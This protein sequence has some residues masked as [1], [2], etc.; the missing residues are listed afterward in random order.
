MFVDLVNEANEKARILPE[1]EV[2]AL[3]PLAVN[4]DQAATE[5]LYWS[6]ARMIL[7]MA[8]KHGG[9]D[10][11]MR[12]DLVGAGIIGFMRCIRSG[13]FDSARGT[14]STYVGWRI[15]GAMLDYINRK[16]PIIRTPSQR[17]PTAHRIVDTFEDGFD[18]PAPPEPESVHDEMEI[19]FRAIES[20]DAREATVVKARYLE[21]KTL[22]E[23][24]DSLH[25]TK[26]RIRQIQLKAVRNLRSALR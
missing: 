21:G 16:R 15:K 13:A 17:P 12:D 23:V 5:S 14:W 8:K 19:V 2:I 4:G 6:T 11:T 9:Q 22:R 10:F 18:V 26:E 1:H 3:Y 24:G 25:L 7:A 20:L